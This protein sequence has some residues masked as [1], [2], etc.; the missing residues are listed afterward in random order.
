MHEDYFRRELANLVALPMHPNVLRYHSSILQGD[1]LHIVTEYIEAYKLS[2]LVPGPN[3]PFPLNHAEATVLSWMAQL[4]DGLAE[5]HRVGMIHH[6]LHGD[7]I[8]IVKDGSTGTPSVG[9]GALRIIDFGVAN[10]YKDGKFQT[11]QDTVNAGCFQ[12]FSPERRNGD[13]FDDRDDVWSAGCHLVELTSG[14]LIRKRQDCGIDGI[15]FATSPSQIAQAIDECATNHLLKTCA[16]CVLVID[17]PRRPRA[18][19]VRDMIRSFWLPPPQ[20]RLQVPGGCKRPLRKTSGGAAGPSGG[21]R[22]VRHC[23]SRRFLETT[24]VLVE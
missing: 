1:Q 3:G 14:R 5:L 16:E 10:V 22:R 6:D 12:Y 11:R 20:I 17:Q 24:V 4:F 8:L 23:S 15:D 2:D 9:A 18:A 19:S 21:G 7:N 13:E